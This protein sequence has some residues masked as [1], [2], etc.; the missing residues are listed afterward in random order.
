[1]DRRTLLGAL[2][3]VACGVTAGC[4]STP[5]ADPVPDLAVL[6]LE[7]HRTDG[8]EFAVRIE[9]KEEDERTV[10]FAETRRLGPAG[11]GD[12]AVAF[13]RPVEPGAYSVRVR[14]AGYSA[15]AETDALVSADE[16]CLRLLFA[17]GHE[18][19]HLE[20]YTYERCDR[21]AGRRERDPGGRQPPLAGSST[22]QG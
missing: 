12:S 9:A 16:P 20:H 6:E 13:E 17:L 1:M 11:S 19:L 10:V 3:G 15:T 7:N 4:L 5:D 22:T 2:G 14:T 8:H 21:P 18:T